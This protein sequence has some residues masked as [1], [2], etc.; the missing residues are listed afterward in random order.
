LYEY[1]NIV[2]STLIMIMAVCFLEDLDLDLDLD[3]LSFKRV[4]RWLKGTPVR[5]LKSAGRFATSIG[6]SLQTVV[7]T[8]L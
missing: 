2:D 8:L 5:R 7:Y 6:F 3:W 1:T 4:P